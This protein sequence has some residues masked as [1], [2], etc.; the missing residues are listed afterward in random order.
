MS[1]IRHG[2]DVSE[3]ETNLAVNAYLYIDG[4]EGPS[5]SKDNCIDIVSF[6]WGVNQTSTYGAGQSGKEAKAGRADFSNLTITK[7]LDKTTPYLCAHCASGDILDEVYVL[8]DK[9]VGDK[10]EDYFR[11]YLKDALIT[12]VH[13]SGSNENPTETVSF[14]FQAT[15][16]AYRAENDDGTLDGAISKGYDLESLTE[17]YAAP[18]GLGS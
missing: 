11:V 3:K 9:P 10:Q 2:S 12:N 15:E 13:L 4:I 16:I 14:A 17:N 1:R 6:S 8:Y 5:T 7:V 18:S